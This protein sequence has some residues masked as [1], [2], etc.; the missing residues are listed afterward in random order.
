MNVY[1]LDNSVGF[2]ATQLCSLRIVIYP[3]KSTSHW[4]YHNQLDKSIGFADAY[5]IIFTQ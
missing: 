3:L 5:P 1:P 4:I 2:D